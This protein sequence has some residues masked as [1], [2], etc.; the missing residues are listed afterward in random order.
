MYSEEGLL[1]RIIVVSLV[2]L[3]GIHYADVLPIGDPLLIS[4]YAA[5]A[6]IGLFIT[7]KC[8]YVVGMCLFGHHLRLCDSRVDLVASYR[9]Q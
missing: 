2:V 4:G 7:F 6:C 1:L 9:N 8:L 3:S 5:L